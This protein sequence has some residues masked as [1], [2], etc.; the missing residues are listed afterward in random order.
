MPKGWKPSER[1]D[2]LIMLEDFYIG[3]RYFGKGSHVRADDVLANKLLYECPDWVD[4]VDL[5]ALNERK[6]D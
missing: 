1:F 2:Y 6:E 3:S 5:T 4:P